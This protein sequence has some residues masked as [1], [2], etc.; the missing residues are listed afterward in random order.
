RTARDA[1]LMIA[2]AG[3]H[4]PALLRPPALV[5]GDAVGVVAPSYAPRPGWLLRGVKAL[6][7]AGFQVILDPEITQGRRF[8]R[9]ED[10]RRAENFM[11]VWL[12]PRVKAVIGGTGGYG[13]V[14]ML[15]YLEPEIFRRN[16]KPFVGYSDITALH[17]W[18][19]RRSGLR[20]FHGPTVDDLIPS[21]RDPTM[22]SLLTAL[23][24]PRPT[25]RIGKGIARVVR[26]G[27]AV[28]RLIGGNLSLVQQ[29]IGTPY[30]VDTRDAILFLE[31][32][33]DPMSVLDERLVHLRAAGLLRGVR[34]VVFGQLSIDRSEEDEFEDFLLDLVSDLNV[35]ILTD[36]PAGHEVPNLT[37]PIGTE[38]ELVAEE[39]TGW[40][41]YREDALEAAARGADGG[42]PAGVMAAG[43]I[44]E[45]V[46][47]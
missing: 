35:P 40:I 10:E 29:T 27:R 41:A 33:R 6:E 44:G 20:V 26:P 30:E 42:R 5:K 34:G 14:R 11:G 31:E 3:E 13:A 1:H 37:L 24:T 23:T 32:T 47:L 17:L 12:D 39:T 15:P 4:P 36:F 25:T 8:K 19:M 28:G 38:V 21:T 43:R 16:P 22:A 45:S 18:L 2:E 46:S 9:A 7:H